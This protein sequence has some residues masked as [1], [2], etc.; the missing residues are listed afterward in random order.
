MKNGSDL[1][2]TV[3]STATIGSMTTIAAKRVWVRSMLTVRGS[4]S[5]DD[6]KEKQQAI[7]ARQEVSHCKG[8]LIF[9]LPVGCTINFCSNINLKGTCQQTLIRKIAPSNRCLVGPLQQAT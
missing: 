1:D 2:D 3:R 9:L 7:D 5:R 4:D 6:V 8:D